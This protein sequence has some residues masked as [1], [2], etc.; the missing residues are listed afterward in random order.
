MLKVVYTKSFLRQ[1]KKLT[2]NIKTKTKQAIKKFQKNPKDESLKSHKLNG[3]LADF[4]SFSVDYNLRIVF[5]LD[6]KG[7]RAVFLKIGSHDVYR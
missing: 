4:Y 1:Y 6:K 2:P 5:E 7:N 3:S